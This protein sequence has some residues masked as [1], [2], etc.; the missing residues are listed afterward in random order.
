M[1]S[2]IPVTRMTR[3]MTRMAKIDGIIARSR[4][5]INMPFIASS[6]LS[7]AQVAKLRVAVIGLDATENGRAILKK[8]G[9]PAGFKET[10]REEFV[11]F[12]KWLGEEVKPH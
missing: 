12:L 2:V 6:E 1:L 8:I 5:Q 4:D 3:N 7:E 9:L 10:P 11:A